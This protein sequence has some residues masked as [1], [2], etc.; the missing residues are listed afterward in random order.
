MSDFPS[1]DL[2]ELKTWKVCILEFPSLDLIESKT[3]KVG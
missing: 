1:L 2:I 3:W